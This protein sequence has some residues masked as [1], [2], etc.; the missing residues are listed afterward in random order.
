MVAESQRLVDI[1]AN[2]THRQIVDD[3]DELLGRADAAG[4]DRVVATGTTL[5]S[6]RESATLAASRAGVYATAGI[7]PHHAS[8]CDGDTR[9][10]LTLLLNKPGVVA[11][12]ECGLDYDRNFSAPEVQRKWYAA[13]LRLAADLQ[14][15]VFLH[16]RAAHLDFAAIL[17]EHRSSLTDGV[18]HC[19]TGTAAELDV[20]LELDM[21]IG[22]TG[23]ICDERRGLHLRE[24]VP[25]I[26]ASRL[27][28]ETD[29]PFLLP[30]TI[31]PRP[32]SRRNEPAFLTHV[33]DAVANAASRSRDQVAA[34]TTATAERF[35]GLN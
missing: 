16:E 13:Q 5:A 34:E 7:H 15:P 35:F 32:K 14:L 33:L 24:L 6:S 20:Y 28:I 21:H 30:R 4:V 1:G 23:W 22:V 8:E 2:L 10:H 29:A 25:R 26:P 11:V 12:G 17:R 31:R 9:E 27:M 18:V 3:L 19:F